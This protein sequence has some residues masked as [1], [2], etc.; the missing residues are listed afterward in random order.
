MENWL[1]ILYQSG[2][3]KNKGG[4]GESSRRGLFTKARAGFRKSA[5]DRPVL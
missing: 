2:L 4:F 3:S 1:R 5:R